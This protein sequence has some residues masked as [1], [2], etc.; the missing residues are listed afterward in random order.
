MIQVDKINFL[1][2]LF[3]AE[4]KSKGVTDTDSNYIYADIIF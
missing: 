4:M 1:M 2:P 3:S